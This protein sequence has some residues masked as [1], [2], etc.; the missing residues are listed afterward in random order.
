VTLLAG[1]AHQPPTS[2]LV[3]ARGERS[4]AVVGFAERGGVREPRA[5]AC[6]VTPGGWDA[7]LIA[8]DAVFGD[9]DR[10]NQRITT[11]R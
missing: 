11:R 9:R 5:A 4:G 7:D 1:G 10:V 6:H 2:V 8:Y 3:P